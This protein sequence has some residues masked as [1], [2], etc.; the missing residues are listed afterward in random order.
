MHSVTRTVDQSV[1]CSP[2]RQCPHSDRDS[3]RDDDDH[4]SG[5]ESAQRDGRGERWVVVVMVVMEVIDYVVLV[6]AVA[7][8]VVVDAIGWTHLS[9][10]SLHCWM[11]TVMMTILV[12]MMECDMGSDSR[13][14][15]WGHH[16]HHQ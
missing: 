10:L 2:N 1:E 3:D 13:D 14:K 5:A 9:S 12:R 15:R 16:H 8:A 4:C 11:M 7:V 6:V